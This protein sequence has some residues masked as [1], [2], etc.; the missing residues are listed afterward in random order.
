MP[1]VLLVVDD[2]PSVLLLVDVLAEK[3]GWLRVLEASDNPELFEFD[4]IATP[5]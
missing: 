4:G 3:L 5:K 2:D 1:P